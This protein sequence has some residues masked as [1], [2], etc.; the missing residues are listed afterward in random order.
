[1]YL[2]SSGSAFSLDILD[3]AVINCS[4]QMSFV[5]LSIYWLQT[6]K[7]YHPYPYEKGFEAKVGW[8]SC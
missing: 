3:S 2:I 5:L 7:H 1:M 8:K 6:G 4:P